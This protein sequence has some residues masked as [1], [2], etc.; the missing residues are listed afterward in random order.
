[1]LGRNIGNGGIACKRSRLLQLYELFAFI[2]FILLSSTFIFVLSSSSWAQ[3]VPSS[4]E[5]DRLEDSFQRAPAPRSE[6]ETPAGDAQE[7]VAPDENAETVR[8][9]LSGLVIEGATVFETADLLPLYEDLLGQ[10]VALAD[11]YDIAEQVTAHY[12][13]DG[14]FLSRAI[15][16]PQRISGGIVRIQVIEGYISS[17]SFEGGSDTHIVYLHEYAE[18]IMEA[19]PISMAVLERYLLLANDLPGID[20][21]SIIRPA[22]DQPG[23]S[24][25]VLV[26]EQDDIELS[27]GADNFGSRFVGPYRARTQV[28]EFANL[29]AGSENSI[30]Y[31]TSAGAEAS[32]W[33]ELDFFELTHVEHIGFEGL[34]VTGNVGFVRSEPGSTLNA[35]DI[36]SQSASAELSVS[37]PIFRSR[38]FSLIAEGA[39]AARNSSTDLLGERLF[40]DNIRTIQAGFT[41]DYADTLDGLTLIHGAVTKGLPIL[42]HSDSNSSSLS[43][44]NAR[45]DFLK[46]SGEAYRIQNLPY[47]LSLMTTAMG[48]ISADP[49]VSGEEFGVG[50][51][52]IGRGYA[53]SEITGDH[54]VA[55]A[56]ELRWT[57]PVDIPYFDNYQLFGF[58]DFGAVV[59]YQTDDMDTLASAGGGIRT[60]MFD[61]LDASILFGQPLTRDS[62]GRTDDILGLDGRWLFEVNAVF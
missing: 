11:I 43:R 44:S 35:L 33:R 27:L 3:Q 47:Q 41:A 19:R 18:S 22:S 20:A 39:F 53:P 12:R 45:T 21:R 49:L 16:P 59:D 38:S 48:Q 26:V 31:M 5:A 30:S 4:V 60:E 54:G 37:Y 28:R 23:A 2:L 32:D 13:A 46:F 10:E 50:G 52:V 58:Y 14:F 17:V 7:E 61:N 56:V 34:T 62:D 42:G 29:W 8:F 24:E 51:P 57:P 6:A 15:V 55:A 36:V 40:E 1:M 9:V 25:L